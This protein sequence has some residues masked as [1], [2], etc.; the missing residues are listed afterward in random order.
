MKLFFE[1]NKINFEGKAD[2]PEEGIFDEIIE[3]TLNTFDVKIGFGTLVI[4]DEFLRGV[5]VITATVIDS[6]G[7]VTH[8][9][10]QI[11]ILEKDPLMIIEDLETEIQN[12]IDKGYLPKGLGKSLSGSKTQS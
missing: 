2:D 6:G 5:H 10:V 4:V 12:S 1:G 3:W 8:D 7:L 11:E 9:S